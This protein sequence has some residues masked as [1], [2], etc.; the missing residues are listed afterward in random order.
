MG[1]ESFDFIIVGGGLAGLVLATR[2][3]EDPSTTVLVIEAG[4]DIRDDPR[5]NIPAMWPTLLDDPHASMQLKTVPQVC[6]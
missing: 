2:L 1:S 3:S 5:V 6:I 4:Q